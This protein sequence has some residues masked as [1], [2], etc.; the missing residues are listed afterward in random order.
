MAPPRGFRAFL[1]RAQLLALLSAAS[2]SLLW[3]AGAYAAVTKTGS[4]CTVREGKTIFCVNATLEN[5][6]VSYELTALTSPPEDVGWMALGFGVNMVK[7]HMMIMWK[8]ED[9]SMTMSQ[10]YAKWYSEPMVLR[11][12][13]EPTLSA[14][15]SHPFGNPRTRTTQPSHSTFQRM[16]G[17]LN[18]T[19]DHE[20]L[21]WAT[22]PIRP[23]KTTSP[24][25]H[26]TSKSAT[27]VSTS[28]PPQASGSPSQP[29]ARPVP[30][31][32]SDP[33]KRPGLPTDAPTSEEG[34]DGNRH[35]HDHSGH[36]RTVHAHAY[37]MSFGLL[38]VLPM[39]VLAARWG[40]TLSPLWFRV[41][42]VLN[43]LVAGPVV[44]LGWFLGAASVYKHGGSHLDD[45]HKICGTVLL[46]F[47]VGQVVLGRYIHRRR[48]ET[49]GPIVKPHPPRNLAH[50]AFGLLF[51]VSVFF[52]VR[53]GLDKLRL[54]EDEAPFA[55]W[56]HKLWLIW[57]GVL[58]L[59]YLPGLL[60]LQRQWRQERSGSADPSKAANYV[61]LA[62]TA[63]Q[64]TDPSSSTRLLFEE[65]N[66]E[67]FKVGE[68]EGESEEEESSEDEETFKAHTTTLKA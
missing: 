47:Y 38:F 4:T 32:D 42:W 27:S 33:S 56:Y 29:P 53:S 23:G 10:R 52:Q 30:G 46:L 2:T 43:M 58:P 16:K 13:V 31:Q 11:P 48:V 49:K 21:I 22:S 60:L 34:H 14:V 45:A 64:G 67:A 63:Q 37:L 8:N 1:A 25:S 65:E 20:R 55:R 62:E 35:P 15:S 9:G 54:E 24:T 17:L 3:A 6:V 51:I 66:R 5:D 61:Q 28:H 57:A 36:E 40:R 12:A 26:G 50:I 39:G 19:I 68:E 59:L 7:S 44:L 41:H 18:G